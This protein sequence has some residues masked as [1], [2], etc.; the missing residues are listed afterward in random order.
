MFLALE[1]YE[2]FIYTLVE[3]FPS[4]ESSRLVLKRLGANKAVLEG[5]VHFPNQIKLQVFEAINFRKR[6]IRQYS[7]DVY[8]GDEQLYW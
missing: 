3:H 5:E 1:D 8:R 4:V 6:L 7:Y 2:L